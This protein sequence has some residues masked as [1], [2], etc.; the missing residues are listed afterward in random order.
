MKQYAGLD[1]SLKEILICVVDTDGTVLLRGT[2]ATDPQAVPAFW[3]SIKS[4]LSV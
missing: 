2:V 3:R 1:V 4:P